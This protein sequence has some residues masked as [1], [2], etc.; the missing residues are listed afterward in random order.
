MTEPHR[1]WTD[2]PAEDAGLADI[3][4]RRFA[5]Y[6]AYGTPNSSPEAQQAFKALPFGT[7]MRIS[8][9]F[10]A[11]LFGPLYFFAKGM[12]RKGLS[13]LGLGLAL[14]VVVAYTDFGGAIDRA[15]NFVVPMIALLTANW[16]Y[17]LQVRFRSE[18]WNPFEGMT[19]HRPPGRRPEAHAAD[20]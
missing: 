10:L 15:L 1:D 17:Y 8:G 7:R 4:R 13:L 19:S 18:S 20:S 12:W 11:A 14:G 3:W 5:F 6:D 2:Q 16:C 9:N